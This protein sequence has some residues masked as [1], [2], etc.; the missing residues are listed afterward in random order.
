MNK[1]ERDKFRWFCQNA[2]NSQLRAI[3]EKEREAAENAEDTRGSRA[4]CAGIAEAVAS[5]RG[6][7]A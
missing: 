1:R 4:I 7:D 3:V 5:A 6:I 2:S